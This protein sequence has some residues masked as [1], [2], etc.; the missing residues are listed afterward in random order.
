MGG[1]FVAQS[2]NDLAQSRKGLIDILGFFE[3]V[4]SGIGLAYTFRACEI[5]QMQLACVV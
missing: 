1:L 5:D 4:P 3:A 2:I